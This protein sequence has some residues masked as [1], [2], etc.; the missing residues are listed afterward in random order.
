MRKASIVLTIL[1]MTVCCSV[2]AADLLAAGFGA[3]ETQQ[4]SLNDSQQRNHN[5]NQKTNSPASPGTSRVTPQSPVTKLT[6][7]TGKAKFRFYLVSTY[8]PASLATSAAGS[9]INQWRDSVPE[10]GQGMEGYGK[11]FG[12]GYGQKAINN[13]IRSAIGAWLHED[14]RYFPSHTRGI[15]RR[16]EYAA[17]QTLFSHKDDGGI[18]F[19]YSRFV[20]AFLAA[21]ISRQWHPDSYHTTGTYLTAGATS[22]GLSAAKNVFAE[23]WPDIRRRLRF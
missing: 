8:G 17:S 5:Q 2:A 11:R 21:Y 16:T 6:P 13:S 23:F 7:M 19:G 15:R 4:F 18:R 14:P 20:A 3:G 10:W 1:V 9:G 22:I 12:S